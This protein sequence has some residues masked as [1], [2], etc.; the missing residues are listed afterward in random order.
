MVGLG[1]VGIGEAWQA[2]QV[3]VRHGRPGEAGLVKA[4]SGRVGRGVAGLVGLGKVVFGWVW[5]GMVR[6]ARQGQVSLGV[7]RSGRLG[8]VSPGLE[9]CG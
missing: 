3:M 2:R 9:G 4:W 1:K 5:I 6:Q 8:L 7:E